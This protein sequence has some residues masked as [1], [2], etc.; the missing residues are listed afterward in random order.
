MCGVHTNTSSEQVLCSKPPEASCISKEFCRKENIVN[1]FIV[2]TGIDPL[3]N[4]ECALRCYNMP[5]HGDCINNKCSAPTQPAIPIFDPEN[6]DCDGART[7]PTADEV[8][9]DFIEGSSLAGQVLGL[10]RVAVVGILALEMLLQAFNNFQ[11]SRF[12]LT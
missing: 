7:P 1:C 2:T 6:P 4:P 12:G 9:L 10:H 8:T 5:T 11:V 3:G